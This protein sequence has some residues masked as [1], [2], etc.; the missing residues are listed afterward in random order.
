V[1]NHVVEPEASN[2]AEPTTGLA[3]QEEKESDKKETIDV[4]P[5]TV[6]PMDND[7]LRSFV[8]KAPYPE[9]LRVPK[10]NA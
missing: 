9:R 7:P 5:S 4:E 3:R 8:L 1:D 2:E 6:T 10:K